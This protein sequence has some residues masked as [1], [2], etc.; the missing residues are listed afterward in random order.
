MGHAASLHRNGVYRPGCAGPRASRVNHPVSFIFQRLVE[1]PNLEV[2]TLR[3]IIDRLTVTR[4]RGLPPPEGSDTTDV[5]FSMSRWDFAYNLI[6]IRKASRAKALVRFGSR[7]Y[8]SLDAKPDVSD[9]IQRDKFFEAHRL[10]DRCFDDVRIERTCVFS[11]NSKPL[12]CGYTGWR[13]FL[14][15]QRS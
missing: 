13:S 2:D 14:F 15:R 7:F 6:G 4:T 11:F 1:L 12:S 10:V 5:G 3:F 9:A 8:R